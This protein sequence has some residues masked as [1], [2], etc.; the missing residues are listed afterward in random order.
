M[1]KKI[2]F[3]SR[4]L[5]TFSLIIALFTVGIILF[6]QNQIRKERTESLELNLENNADIIYSY[7]TENNLSPGDNKDEIDRQLKYMQPELRLTIIDWHG[8]VV[9]DNILDENSMENHLQRPE[10]QK[11]IGY[12]KGSN[13]RDR[14]SVV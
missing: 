7:L 9:Y 13:I 12:G 10:I 6:E 4:I 2:S 14:K 1:K 11:T 8:E 5:I 3:K